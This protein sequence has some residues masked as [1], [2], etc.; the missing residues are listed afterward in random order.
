MSLRTILRRETSADHRALDA[1][2]DKLRLFE[3]LTGYG[4]WLVA[5]H[6]FH[7]HI[8][9]AF[10]RREL[11]GRDAH[12]SAER[13]RL[14]KS[15]MFDL[16]IA[17]KAMEHL[18]PLTISEHGSRLGVLYVTEGARLGARVLIRRATVMGCTGSF[19]GRHLAAEA[20]NLTPWRDVLSMLATSDLDEAATRSAV[21]AGQRTFALAAECFN[22]C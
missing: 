12:W 18:K 10:A 16:G 5:I 11:A 3:D 21:L 7:N 20:A 9:N 6:A 4:R 17:P 1:L 8:A 22:G 19:G 14:L 15:D 13:I 2:T